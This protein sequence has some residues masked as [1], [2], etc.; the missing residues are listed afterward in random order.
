MNGVEAGA[1]GDGHEGDSRLR[2][3]AGS[4]P[5]LDGGGGADVCFGVLVEISDADCE[6][7]DEGI[8]SR[9]KMADQAQCAR[10]VGA[11]ASNERTGKPRKDRQAKARTPNDWTGMYA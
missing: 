8:A 9:A 2:V 10:R 5:A 11:A 4:H 1:I 3:A 7:S 6:H